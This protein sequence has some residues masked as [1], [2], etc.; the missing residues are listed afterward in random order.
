MPNSVFKQRL[1]SKQTVAGAMV[2]EFFTPGIARIMANAGAEFVIFDMEHSGLG[3]ETLKWLIASCHGLPFEPMVRVP[4]GDYAYLSRALDMG[5]RGV[6]IPMVESKAQAEHIVECCLYPGAGRRGAAFGFAQCDYRG[7]DIAAK[8]ADYNE[9][10]TIIA[11]IESERGM[12][13]LDQIAAVDGID[14]LWVGQIDL[15]NFLGIPGQ[16]DNPVFLKALERVAQAAKANGKVAAFMMNDPAWLEKLRPLGYSMIAAGPDP[17]LLT[18]AYS[19]M[20]GEISK[21]KT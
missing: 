7:G 13:N 18:Q 9:R 4:L 16:F 10:T 6:M 21:A 3:Y 19:R 5:A 15:S 20:I 2:F 14:V 1:F 12:D 17:A 8:V 11:Q